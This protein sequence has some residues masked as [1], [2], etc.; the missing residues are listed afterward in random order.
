ME[1]SP[2]VFL[3]EMQN[4]LQ[5][6]GDALAIAEGEG[7]E[8]GIFSSTRNEGDGLGLCTIRIIKDEETC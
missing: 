3:S 1:Q 4:K 6:S 5:L 7:T 2:N 8:C